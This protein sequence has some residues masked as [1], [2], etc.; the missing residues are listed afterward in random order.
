MIALEK[1]SELGQCTSYFPIHHSSPTRLDQEFVLLHLSSESEHADYPPR[2]RTCELQTS[3]TM[4]Y[5]HLQ[6]FHC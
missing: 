2:F 4:E 3:N 6:H 1:I 5:C